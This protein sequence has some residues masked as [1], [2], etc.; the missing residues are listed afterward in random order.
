MK[1]LI[2]EFIDS[3]RREENRL[4][5]GDNVTRIETVV[6]AA[7]GFAFTILVISI[8]SIPKSPPELLEIPKRHSCVCLQ[9]A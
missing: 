9:R 7:F 5:S 8:D 6:E 2:R 4:V 1:K 3:C